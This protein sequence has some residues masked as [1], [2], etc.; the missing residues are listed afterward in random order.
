DIKYSFLGNPDQCPDGCGVRNPSPNNNGGADALASTFSHELEETLTD[1]DL[2]A[3]QDPSGENADKCAWD[4]GTTY[5][6]S[7]G[8]TANMNIHGHDYLIQRNWE[9]NAGACA[10]AAPGSPPP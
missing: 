9:P 5:M 3:Y 10:I 6:T 7:N 4:Y 2:D 8:A 1:P